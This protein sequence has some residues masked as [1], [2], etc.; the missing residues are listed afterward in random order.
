[1]C[2]GGTLRTSEVSLLESVELV[3][4]QGHFGRSW[5]YLDLIVEGGG[6]G[7]TGAGAVDEELVVGRIAG[8]K[9]LELS[10]TCITEQCDCEYK[11]ILRIPILAV[12]T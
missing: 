9:Q 6:V 1:M 11:R 2:E 4:D 5:N 8:S 7:V 12:L 3:S 10:P